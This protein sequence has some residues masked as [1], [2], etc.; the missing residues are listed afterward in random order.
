MAKV[1]ILKKDGTV[2]QYYWSSTDSGAPTGVAVYK[3][4]DDGMKRMRGVSFNT[5]T[6]CMR[7]QTKP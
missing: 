5:V 6:N 3:R 1:R 2:T 4:T 7:R